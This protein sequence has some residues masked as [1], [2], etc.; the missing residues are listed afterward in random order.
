MYIKFSS[1][2]TF[3]FQSCTIRLERYSIDSQVPISTKISFRNFN[4]LSLFSQ[5]IYTSHLLL[6]VFITWFVL[7]PAHNFVKS[8]KQKLIARKDDID[9]F[10]KQL[11]ECLYTIQSFYSNTNWVEMYGGVA[12][13]DFGKYKENKMFVKSK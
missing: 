10:I 9:E 13:D 5:F 2:Y 1:P 8:C 7:I 4:Y 6:L 12:Y 3:H 11:G